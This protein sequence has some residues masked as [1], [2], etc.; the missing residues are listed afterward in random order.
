MKRPCILLFS[1]APFLLCAQTTTRNPAI[2]NF[3]TR[4]TKLEREVQSKKC[5]N[6]PAGAGEVKGFHLFLEGELL[7]MKAEED[8]LTYTYKT[9]NAEG[10]SN[11]ENEIRLEEM[12]F[13]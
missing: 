10:L 11:V 2:K 12:D 5:F 9:N 13:D 7:W 1:L 4:L 3:N 8:G 6:P